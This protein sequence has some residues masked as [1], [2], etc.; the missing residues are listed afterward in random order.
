MQSVLIL[1]KL[2]IGYVLILLSFCEINDMDIVS[3]CCILTRLDK[4]KESV[5]SF[6]RAVQLDHFFIDAYIGR[7]NAFMDYG[8]EIG[9]DYAR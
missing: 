4:L 9:H 6:T 7:G 3:F 8:H 1:L 2:L 5:Q